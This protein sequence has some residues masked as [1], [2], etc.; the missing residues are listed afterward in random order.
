MKKLLSLC[1]ILFLL[2]CGNI[3]SQKKPD[4]AIS[5]G[6]TFGSYTGGDFGRIWAVSFPGSS[7]HDDYYYNSYYHHNNYDNYN[8]YGPIILDLGMDF[9]INNYA[10]INLESSFIWHFN[11]YPN[12]AYETGEIHGTSYVDKWE[13]ANLFAVPL[14]LNLKLFP[15]GRQRS[16]FYLTAGYG[17]QYT[18]ESVDRVREEYN[19]NHGYYEDSYVIGYASS[20]KWL[21][22][23]KLG[24]GFVFPISPYM[25]GEAEFKVTNFYPERNPLSPLAMNSSTNI[26]FIGLTTKVIFG[27]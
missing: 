2:F 23:F 21:G 12:G 20:K 10:A 5:F 17:Q 19:Y 11:G 9:F 24:M 26:T 1:I 25:S 3:Y 8:F 27:F 14:F 4:F 6:T 18:S 13:N 7:Y 16:A 15:L 22:G